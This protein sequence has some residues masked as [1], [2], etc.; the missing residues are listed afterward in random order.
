MHALNAFK[1]FRTGQVNHPVR[2][3]EVSVFLCCPDAE[4]PS[5]TVRV[6]PAVEAPLSGRNAA[7]L[8][9]TVSRLS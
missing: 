5:K 4:D 7:D 8:K 3:Y 9:L 2:F 6:E 1:S